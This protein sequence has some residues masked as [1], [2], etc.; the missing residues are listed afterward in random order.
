MIFKLLVV[1]WV[2]FLLSILL[3]AYLCAWG[4]EPKY[5]FLPMASFG[6][7]CAIFMISDYLWEGVW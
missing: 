1:S 5:S 7:L 2:L 3:G 4:I 6:S